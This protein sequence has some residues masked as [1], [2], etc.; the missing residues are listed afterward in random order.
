V[1]SI[2]HQHAARQFV[3]KRTEP[4]LLTI[5]NPLFASTGVQPGILPVQLLHGLMTLNLLM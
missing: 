5:P 1:Q 2:D 3:T 4:T